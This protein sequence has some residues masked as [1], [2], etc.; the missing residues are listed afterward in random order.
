MLA[1]EG[2]E[3]SPAEMVDYWVDL[4]GRYPIVSIEDG[5]AEEDWDGW[6]ALTKALGGKVQLVGDD[7]FVT[8]PERLAR[9]IGKGVANSLLVKL[10]QIGTLTETL[11]TMDMARSAAYTCVVSH[12]SG[13]TEDTIGRR[14]C[15]R[16]ELRSAQGRRACQVRPGCKVQQAAADRRG[17]R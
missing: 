6:A 13:E 17:A 8:N 11:D 3:L 5:M 14:P 16:H 15:G 1:G 10:N 12:R 2:R 9:G 4:A 7:V